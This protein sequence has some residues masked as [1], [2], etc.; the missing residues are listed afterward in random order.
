MRSPANLAK[1]IRK[2]LHDYGSPE[3]AAGVQRFFTEPVA[4]HG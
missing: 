2:L 1:H 4:S 3:H